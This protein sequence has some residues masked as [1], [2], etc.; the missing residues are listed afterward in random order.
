MGGGG[1][2]SGMVSD[3]G[4]FGKMSAEAKNASLCST[5]KL[6]QVLVF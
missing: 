1:L 3:E 5:A 4:K 6:V 2:A